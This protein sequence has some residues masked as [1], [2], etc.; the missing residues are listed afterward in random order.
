MN[1]GVNYVLDHVLVPRLFLDLTRNLGVQP[2]ISPTDLLWICSVWD[3]RL[4][5]DVQ[6]WAWWVVADWFERVGKGQ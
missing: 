3:L 2:R 5:G 4:G 1:A 6:W